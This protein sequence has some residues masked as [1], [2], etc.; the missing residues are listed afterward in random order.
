MSS[1]TV[2]SI[3]F[4][5]SASLVSWHCFRMK[6]ERLIKYQKHTRKDVTI[7]KWIQSWL[8]SWLKRAININSCQFIRTF[9]Y[10]LVFILSLRINTWSHLGLIAIP[11]SFRYLPFNRKN[12]RGDPDNQH[13][14][15][16][17]RNVGVP[18]S[19]TRDRCG[20]RPRARNNSETVICRDGEHCGEARPRH[21][22]PNNRGGRLSGWLIYI[23]LSITSDAACVTLG[24]CYW[25]EHTFLHSIFLPFSL[26]LSCPNVPRDCAC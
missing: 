2:E 8:W 17:S 14:C 18:H 7:R 25:L 24:S 5:W 15:H 16:D 12:P 1:Q 26:F 13:A 10:Y 4:R 22:F 19:A 9:W 11:L 6:V 20:I 23:S 3:T 21:F